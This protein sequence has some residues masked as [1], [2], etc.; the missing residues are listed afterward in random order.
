MDRMAQAFA[1]YWRNSLAD[2]NFSIGGISEKDTKAF[3]ICGDQ[4]MQSGHIDKTKTEKLFKDEPVDCNTI[5]IVIRPIVYR[6]QVNHTI[7][8]SQDTPDYVIPLVTDALLTRNGRCYP[9]QN[10]THISRDILEPLVK[11]SFS[12]GL[13]NELDDYLTINTLSGINYTNDKEDNELSDNEYNDYWCKYREDIESL[14]NHVA[15]EW[16]KD[17]QSFKRI[18]D[19]YI[20]KKNAIKDIFKNI[21]PVYDKLRISSENIP[22]FENITAKLPT[23]K[24]PCLSS[25]SL[26]S[27]RLAHASEQFPLATAQCDALIHL[28]NAKNG[29]TLAVNGPPGTGKTTMLLS[30]VASLWAKH[31]LEK[32]NPPVI[33]AASTNNQAVTNILDAFE[34]GFSKGDEPFGG[35]WLPNVKSFGAYFPSITKAEK[36]AESY[37]TESFY[38]TV[39]NPKY[40]K[41]AKSYYIKKA[42]EAFEDID[43]ESIKVSAIVDKLHDSIKNEVEKLNQIE[44][45]WKSL[46][47]IKDKIQK[48]FCDDPYQVRKNQ[49]QQLAQL[50][51]N[52]KEWQNLENSWQQY[53]VDESLWYS[54][55]SFLPLI[56]QKRLLKANL[57]LKSLWPFGSQQ[58]KWKIIDEITLFISNQINAIEPLIE[59]NQRVI[60]NLEKLINELEKCQENWGLALR[61]LDIKENTKTIDLEQ[62]DSIADTKIRFKIFLLTTHYWEGRWLSKMEELLPTLSQW[63]RKTGKSIIEERWYLRMMLTPCVVSTLYTLPKYFKYVGANYVNDYLYNYADLLIVDEAG[64]VLP[65][66][67]GASFA[68]SKKALVIGDIAQIEP[69]WAIPAKVDI[70]NLLEAEVIVTDDIEQEYNK[71]TNLGV[72]ASSGSIMKIAQNSSR[73]HYDPDLEPGMYLYEHRRCYDEI[74]TFCNELIYKGKLKPKRGRKSEG[75]LFPALGYLHIDGI[76][77]QSGSCSRLNKLE[78]KVIA[79]WLAS[80]KSELEEKYNKPLHEIVGI[81]T[82]FSGQANEIKQAIRKLK[83]CND[84]K[85]TIG[86]VHSLQGAEKEL[87][88]FSTVYS[89]HNN[90]HFIDNQPSILNVAVSRAKDSFLV[91]GDMDILDPHLNTPMGTLANFLMASETNKLH[92]KSIERKDLIESSSTNLQVLR[93]AKEHD[94]FLIETINTAKKEI[95]IVSPWL[96]EN[97]IESSKILPL[98]ESA[99]KKGITVTVF[100]DSELNITNNAD[101]KLFAL[102]DLLKDKQIEVKFVRKIHSKLVIKD[103]DLLCIGSFNWLSAQREGEFARHETS[104]SYQG[105]SKKLSDEIVLIKNS[106]QERLENYSLH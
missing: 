106:L 101:N 103:N 56:A 44:E 55:F 78:A 24:E 18:H 13:V 31:A 105:A 89:K 72:S 92:F 102:E 42:S 81:I 36:A 7:S 75:G 93:D 53:L 16:L 57:Y 68:L 26:F 86:T 63:L 49:K 32:D 99:I 84:Q 9:K 104:L 45:S 33:V 5:E 35:R 47:T 10:G 40:F 29:E 97:A 91:F 41:G 61:H 76:C 48:Q 14:L 73:Y 28:L 64:Q 4:F 23:P 21:L 54:F 43:I 95:I 69:I 11:G 98:L 20:I 22:L 74:I 52:K 82:P 94:D 6:K 3:T 8:H 85:L 39:E 90:G 71:L 79:K 19:S 25:N 83:V 30:V 1:S 67:A 70:G 2:S 62:A 46:T 50:E 80:Y 27:K 96:T 38:E 15:K 100:I 34:K 87:I 65:E 66:V 59:E 37:Q 12:I 77:Q 17:T 60:E 88:I 51:E 58:P